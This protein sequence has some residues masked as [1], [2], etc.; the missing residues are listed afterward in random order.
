MK[1]CANKDVNKLIRQFLRKGW[2]FSHSKK[3]GRLTHPKGFP[4]ITISKTPSDSR[5]VMNIR[6]DLLRACR[7]QN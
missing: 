4:V 7:D 5:C 1:Y 6:N 3:H 2:S